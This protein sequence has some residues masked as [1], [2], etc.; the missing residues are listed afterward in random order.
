M[1][2]LFYL[3][4]LFGSFQLASAQNRTVSGVV[5]DAIDGSTI[6]GV[7]VRILGADGGTISDIDGNYT[8]SVPSST[9][10]L[11][12]SFMGMETKTVSISGI[13]SL[14]V[15]LSSSAVAVEELV[16]VGYGSQRKESVVGSVVQAKGSE[17]LKAG[18]VATVS[19]A[20]A[21]ILPGVSTMQASGQ[22]GSSDATILIR[23]QS[24]WGDNSP[25]FVVDGVERDFNNLD[26]NEI[27]SISVLKDASA[28]AVFG[29][30]GANGVI[31]ITTKRGKEGKARVNY[32]GNWG[33]KTPVMETDYLKDY[34]T[35][36]EYFSAAAMAEG[37]YN[38]LVPQSEIDA[39][40]MNPAEQVAWEAQMRATHGDDW[41]YQY[42]DFYSYTNWIDQLIDKGYTQAHNINISGGNSFVKYFTSLGYNYDGDIF[43]LEKT[44]EYDPRTYQK[45]YNWRSN[46]DFDF[47]ESTKLKVNLAGNFKDWHG[48]QVTGAWNRI[49]NSGADNTSASNNSYIGSMFTNLQVGAAP[50]LSTGDI[51]VGNRFTEW[52]TYNYLAQ[53]QE[54]GEVTKRTTQIFTDII[55]EQRFLKD[56][57]FK[58]KVSYNFSRQYQA[59]ITKDPLYYSTDWLSGTVNQE[60]DQD[61]VESLASIT[62]EY[63]NA[64]SNS[65]YYEGSLNY[66]KT[67]AD[68]HNVSALA[69]FSRRQ[70]QNQ[71]A[72]PSY[73]ESWV[74]RATYN[75]KLKYMF[76]FNGA[77]NGS[78]NWAPGLKFGFFPSVAMGWTISEEPFFKN[79]INFMNF[80][81]LRYSW[82]EVGSDNVSNRFTYIQDYT[83]RSGSAAGL[84]GYGE[85]YS[86]LDG[87]YFEGSPANIFATWETAVKQNLGMETNMFDNRM[88]LAVDL[89]S[90]NRTGILMERS[91]IPSWY[92]NTAPEANIGATKNHG[93][94]FDLK[95][96]DKINEN[97]SYFATAN[98]SMSENIIIE[99]DDPLYMPDYQKNA[100]KPIGWH[101]GYNVDGYLDSWD[102][103][104]NYTQAAGV[105]RIPGD[106]VYTDY[107][108]DGNV[109]QD[110]EIPIASP[111]YTS[112]SFAMSLGV[113]YKQW[114]MSAM[115]NGSLG[116]SKQLSTNYLW[117]YAT[118]GGSREFRVLDTEMTDQWS[119]TNLD[120]SSPIIHTST[121]AYNDWGKTTYSVRSSDYVRL[122]TLELK[123]T[124]T[125]ESLHRLKIVQ[126]LE[127]YA[128]GYNL[129]TWTSLPDMFDPEASKLE[130]YPITKR[131]TFGLRANF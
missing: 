11:Q 27:E 68:N 109:N 79:N 51:G 37:K 10:E 21:G 17:L 25:L 130:V 122:R 102:D 54:N 38:S 74:G 85:P 2:R 48:N 127:V 56:F 114:S 43:D 70:A 12:F 117:S 63:L 49:G 22:P 129:L 126:G 23:G 118:T 90:E 64:Y 93:V 5:T 71:L 55:F 88:K 24:T 40:S 28:T 3:L 77:Y 20:L 107:N 47:T 62:S 86:R 81:K 120:A 36:M 58:G 9:T 76:E 60:G 16:V 92:G 97:W 52:A 65:L 35:A 96:N 75:Y 113:S 19:E 13:N 111:S 50:V 91:S 95:W 112:T 84:F 128:N 69:L 110:D 32:S 105:S 116:L 67:I 99:R 131:Y 29:V 121:N 115:F 108:G 59:R 94:E 66:N 72:F 101:S 6:P 44:D 30:K 15:I 42:S 4:L 103:V 14:N 18:S 89:F 61:D 73:E 34:S 82:G 83:Y 104:Y 46:L 106:F 33:V 8:V 7:T 80:L 100:G 26:P 41:D 125:K 31:L 53:M 39:W 1:K 119:P 45:R 78:E 98:M 57:L 87:L 123:Y 124:F